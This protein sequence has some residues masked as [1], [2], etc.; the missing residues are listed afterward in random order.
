[1]SKHIFPPS[2]SLTDQPF[3]EDFGDPKTPCAPVGHPLSE[4][5]WVVIGQIG[6]ATGYVLGIKMLSIGL[7]VAEFGRF[8][9]GLTLI[10]FVQLTL[11]TPLAQ[12]LMRY[13]SVCSTQGHLASFHGIT[14]VWMS[15][16]VW[17]TLSAV[18]VLAIICLVFGQTQWMG[19]VGASL[20][21][22]AFGGC[23]NSDIAI[24]NAARNRKAAAGLNIAAAC[25]KPI[26]GYLFSTSLVRNA[27]LALVGYGAASLVMVVVSRKRVLE[28]HSGSVA[29]PQ[30]GSDHLE[31]ARRILRYS[32]PFLPIGMFSWVQQSADRWALQAI[33]GAEAVGRFAVV[34]QLAFYPM[35]FLASV[36]QLFFMPIAYTRA[37]AHP[38]KA[39]MAWSVLYRMIGIYLVLSALIVGVFHGFSEPLVLLVSRSAYVGYHGFLAGIGI[40]WGLYYLGVMLSGF[41]FVLKESRTYIPAG[42]GS[43]VV[44]AAGCMLGA[45]AY[46]PQGVV[47]GLWLSGGL[48]ALWNGWIAYRLVLISR[49]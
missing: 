26:A 16:L 11:F 45:W 35:V 14:V 20:V 32:W 36:L 10:N 25:L 24:L 31:L 29:R 19:I 47:A 38:E 12:G 46:G 42:L 18:G 39:Y 43:A 30:L 44:A 48:Y 40:G 5:A 15:R 22:G 33:M 17:G 23:V 6:L 41:G 3:P 7:N 8:S 49:R 9:L 37:E 2:G 21:A 4:M 1:M 28:G 13:W 27:E 34:S